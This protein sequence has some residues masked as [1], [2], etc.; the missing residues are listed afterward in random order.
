MLG[1]SNSA[2][3]HHKTIQA[4]SSQVAFHF[5]SEE[6][7]SFFWEDKVRFCFTGIVPPFPLTQD[8]I[9]VEFITTWVMRRKLCNP[10]DKPRQASVS[11][12][13]SIWWGEDMCTKHQA[14][15]YGPGVIY[16]Q[17]VSFCTRTGTQN[18]DVQT[19]IECSVIK[20]H[21]NWNI[22]QTKQS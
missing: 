3:L 14:S 15:S 9:Y 5:Y 1:V 13:T 17:C 4:K 11:V 12:L 18:I 10:Q 16:V 7:E 6:G 20:H 2:I 19:D 8:L 22:S 21:T